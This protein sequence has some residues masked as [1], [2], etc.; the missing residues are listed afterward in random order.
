MLIYIKR[1]KKKFNV[2]QKYVI[3]NFSKVLIISIF[4]RP[5]YNFILSEF[6]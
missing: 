2:T 6:M 1:K 3:F 4:F 5:T